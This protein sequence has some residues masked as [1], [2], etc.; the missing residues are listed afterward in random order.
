[1][2]NISKKP[3]HHIEIVKVKCGKNDVILR[4]P[5][6]RE[7][8]DL[9]FFATGILVLLKTKFFEHGATVTELKNSSSGDGIPS[10]RKALQNLEDCGYIRIIKKGRTNIYREVPEGEV[11]Q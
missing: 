8:S 11:Q 7:D 5:E 10:I 2:F 3:N 1:M 9:S 4:N 6:F